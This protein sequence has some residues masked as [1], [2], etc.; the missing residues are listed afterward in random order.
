MKKTIAFM[1]VFSIIFSLITFN[2]SSV[3]NA[4]P[5]KTVYTVANAHL[6]TVWNW[7]I[8]DTISKYIKNTMTNNF[9]LF[10]KYSDYKFNF[11]GSFRYRLMKEYYPED[12]EKVKKYISEGRWNVAGSA[13]DAGD[14][15]VPSPES[16][17]RQFLYGNNYFED[18]FGKRSVDVFLPDC[19]G[20]GYALP[21]IASHSGLIGF[22]TAKLH[23]G[24][25]VPVP[26]DIGKWVG[27][28]GSYLI[29]ALNTPYDDSVTTDYSNDPGII[30]RI[31]NNINK[32]GIGKIFDYYGARG[33]IGGAPPASAV[34]LIQKAIKSPT[35]PVKVVSAA[36]DQIFRE[37]TQAEI[38]NL[39]S[40]DGEFLMRIHGTGCYT[41]W[42]LL[43]RWNRKNE[44]LADS[45][46][47]SSVAA[48]WLGGKKY[49]QEVLNAAWERFL[50]HQFHDDLP[51]TSLVEAYTD[52]YNDYILSMNQFSEEF[53]TSVQV[54]SAALDT[55]ISQGQPLVVYNPVSFSRED[56]VE[57]QV[58]FNGSAPEYIAVIDP[59]GNEVPSQVIEKV[60]SDTLK[61]VFVAKMPSN[62]YKVFAV[63]PSDKPCSLNTGLSVAEN[64]LENNFYKVTIDENGDISSIFDKKNNKE[65]L[66]NPIRQEM[67]TATPLGYSAWEIKHEDIMAKPRGYVSGSPEI[68]ILEKGPARVS[69]EMKRKTGNSTFTQV[70]SLHSGDDA[71]KVVVDNNVM[72]GERAT[73][74]KAAF[75]LNVSNLRATYDLGLGTI[76]RRTNTPNLYEVPAQ[77]WADLTDKDGSYGVTIMN[78]CKYGWD[79]PNSSTLRLTLIHTPA[80]DYVN[81]G[82]H[83]QDVMDF[84]ENRFSYAI[85]GHK[86]DWIEGRSQKEAAKFNQPLVAFQTTPHEGFLGKEF[87]FSEVS[88]DQVMI[89]AIKK[90]ERS[91]EIII[92]VHE[93]FG[94]EAKGVSIS[95]G[96]GI[97]SVREVNGAEQPVANSTAKVADGKLVFDIGKY[98]PKTFAVKL[99]APVQKVNPAGSEFIELN[100][101][102][103]IISWNSNK[104]DGSF[105]NG[106]Y[107]SF[108]AEIIPDVITSGGVSF[109]TGPKENGKN[110]AVSCE[111]Q[112]IKIPQGSNKL[113]ILAAS[114]NGD[115][116]AT[117]KIDSADVNIKIQDIKEMIGGWDQYGIKHYGWIKKDVVGFEST[118]YHRANKDTYYRKAYMFKYE[119]DVKNK[120][121]LTLPKDT[122]IIIMSITSV[123]NSLPDISASSFLYDEKE[124]PN[125]KNVTVI[126]GEGSGQYPPGV[127]VTVNMDPT[128]SGEVYWIGNIPI[129]DRHAESF[130]FIMPDHDVH[131]AAMI[132]SYGENLVLN[133][134]AKA[135]GSY[136]NELPANAVNGTIKSMNDKW[137]DTS[138]STTKWLSVDLGKEYTIDRWIVKH[139]GVFN[140]PS[141]Y[142]TSDFKLQKSSDG[143]TWE[144][145]DQVIGNKDSVTNRKVEPFTARYVRLYITKA[146]QTNS[147]T[148]RI[149]S[150]ELYSPT[151][152]SIDYDKMDFIFTSPKIELS[153]EK[154][155][156]SML[157]ENKSKHNKGV[158]VAASVY[159]ENNQM[160]YINS[161]FSNVSS[162]GGNFISTHFENIPALK[163][164]DKIK[165]FI[166]DNLNNIRPLMEAQ[167]VEIEQ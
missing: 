157:A 130:T 104:K 154:L 146:T 125:F 84:G 58:T 100:Y 86:G 45:A 161:Y 8:E 28:D 98:Q 36:S 37:M 41:S 150:F 70:I 91:D 68:N 13:V 148:A 95:L 115:K 9:S 44:L 20:F 79:K 48:S 129:N 90:A 123:K 142:N 147:N 42:S 47:R 11:E 57:A 23:W 64:T 118:H 51:G 10:E 83:Y 76:E 87:K 145:V 40:Y 7:T 120:S 39:P 136:Q 80:Q 141:E 22:S 106:G 99:K 164:T 152:T 88:T 143:K 101:N 30:S 29:A 117:F 92:R 167:L 60:S 144:D 3:I 49:P 82:P 73:I 27:V 62:G 155:S 21:S 46:E 66:K 133:K 160:I 159:N 16:L 56:V 149:F 77:Q 67:L 162:S 53:I 121:T 4:E 6:D 5:P 135:S 166:L 65:L 72:W 63:V 113:Y 126:N 18:E 151:E 128:I 94:K 109:K 32:Y 43:K 139:A 38:N 50:W 89:K 103:D 19:F 61:I 165:V 2:Q 97:E 116:K 1:C 55:M 33:D 124:K 14:V 156:V 102:K 114:V 119:I 24:P 158:T 131:L 17:F 93:C 81:N 15:N 74:L 96:N 31:N 69:L 107:S 78:D 26:F 52:T 34:E 105:E 112:T 127:A 137:C 71:N 122:D 35:G 75:S 138:Q 140:E 108:P 59:D 132:N 85:S 134:P 110:N 12:Y 163:N 153:G 54:V 111:G 25:A